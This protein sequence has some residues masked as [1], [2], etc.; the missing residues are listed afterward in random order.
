[1]DLPPEVQARVK[2]LASEF[3]A[4]VLDTQMRAPNTTINDAFIGFITERL[5]RL[6][7]ICEGLIS[8]VNNDPNQPPK[9]GS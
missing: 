2:I 4:Y 8:I 3:K 6:E 1:M 9:D 7:V 5:A